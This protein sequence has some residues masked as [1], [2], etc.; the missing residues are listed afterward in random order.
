MTTRPG[1][2]TAIVITLNE[3]R[4]IGDCL[5][6]LRWADEVIVVDALEHRPHSRRSPGSGAPRS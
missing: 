5:D 6:A 1:T 3:E 4:N 2:V